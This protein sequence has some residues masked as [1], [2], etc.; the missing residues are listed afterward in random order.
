LLT[1]NAASDLVA[2]SRLQASA[3][4]SWPIGA[5]G[6][7]LDPLS[8]ERGQLLEEMDLLRP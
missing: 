2:G 3:F 1:H 8:V 7:A 5:I 4:V 6:G